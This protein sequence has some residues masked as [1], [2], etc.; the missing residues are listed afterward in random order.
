MESLGFLVILLLIAM[1]IQALQREINNNLGTE[2]R[3]D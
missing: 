1:A 3:G 2:S